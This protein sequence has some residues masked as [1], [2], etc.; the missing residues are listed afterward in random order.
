MQWKKTPFAVVLIVC[1]AGAIPLA[2][3]TTSSPYSGTPIALPATLEASKFDKG[4]QNV[5][6]KDLVAGNAGG[7]FRT[8]EDVDIIA[9]ADTVGGPYAINN[10]QTGEWLAYTVNVPQAKN[11][12][13]AI[14]ASNNQATASAFHIEVDGVNVTG[15]IQV[16]KTGSWNTFQW[17]GK[18][19]VP[20]TAGN[21]VIK[22]VSDLQYFNMSAVRAVLSA[23]QPTTPPPPPA[24]SGT[25]Y[26]GTP[27]ALPKAFEASKFDKGG[28]NVA[29][30]DLTA[31]NAGGQFRTTEDVDIIASTDTAGGPYAVNNFQTGEWL[32]Y[33]VNVPSNG[34]YDLA[35]RA[36]NNQATAGTFHMEV[37][38]SNVTQSISVPRTNSWN[39][40]QWFG[41]QNVPLTAGKHVIKVVSEQQ[42]FNMSAVSVL[43][44]AAQTPTTTTTGGTAPSVALTAPTS[45]QTVS[46]MLNYAATVGSGV[47]KVDFS[48]SSAT[49]MALGTKTAAPFGG[50]LDT[51]TLENGS[52]TL[53]A[54]ATD[55]QGNT[56][57]SQVAFSVQNALPAG[58]GTTTKPAGLLFWSGFESGTSLGPI[59]DCYSSGCWQDLLGTDS[60][61]GFTWGKTIAGLPAT[62]FQVR[63][64]TGSNPTTSTISN[65]IV[66]DIQSV[67]GRTG[68]ATRAHHVLMK[69][70]SCTGTAS[71]NPA[72]DCAAQDPYLIQPTA[73]PGDMYISFW[74]KLDPTLTQK[75]V[76][77]WHMVFEW[78]TTGDYRISAQL[79]NYG[80]TQPYWQFRADNVANGGLAYQ[81]FWRIE[82]RTA[83]APVGQWFKF[84][85][86]WHRSKGADGRVW[87]AVN[88]QKL[89]D[90]LG[91]NYGVNG[92]PI[93]RI[94]LTQ[95]YTAATYPIEQWTD[96]V[97]IWSAFP[98]AKAGDPWHDGV[99]GP[100]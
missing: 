50:T 49:P 2:A 66:N 3:Q 33:T 79:V 81:E 23:V 62:G 39:T 28:Q 71:Q 14:R 27:I 45:G 9:S 26:S 63:A 12:D 85:V 55:A 74:R 69:K 41:K 48:V 15:S 29:Y 83:P 76:N 36:S 32:A 54:V 43:A 57:T 82:N 87:M 61:T 99:Y 8:T 93:D 37:D 64:G 58:G 52:H 25:P 70:T 53:T 51:T 86:F 6:Y 80:Q 90:Q 98:T 89:V 34:N 96:D 13:L 73:E 10:F 78:K 75:L 59:R 72:P 16:P 97:Q 5:A 91:P 92:N 100:H 24:Y 60:L 94:F 20:L 84:E 40:F 21:H 44:S 88:G 38:G 65:Y 56:A 35:I 95:L 17:F 42:Y 47:T 11:Y 77:G 68:A 18:Q 19:S 30:K 67:T 22:V 4:G 46:G 7:Q 31:G 1:G